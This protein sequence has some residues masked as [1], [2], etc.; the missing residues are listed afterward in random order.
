[1]GWMYST[2]HALNVPHK[3][4]LMNGLVT[5]F[6]Q[7]DEVRSQKL[8]GLAYVC[9]CVPRMCTCMFFSRSFELPTSIHVHGYGTY[10]T[11]SRTYVFEVE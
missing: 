8:N 7:V 5:T 1:M 10:S 3:I 9:M 11:H 2:K 6:D 4:K